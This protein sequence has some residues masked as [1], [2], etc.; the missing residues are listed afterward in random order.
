MPIEKGQ[1]Q[2]IADSKKVQFRYRNKNGILKNAKITLSTIKTFG[3]EY[4]PIASKCF[5]QE[6]NGKFYLLEVLVIL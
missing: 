5:K 6:F 4:K 3:I 2:W 1:R